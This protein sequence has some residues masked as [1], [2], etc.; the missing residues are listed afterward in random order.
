MNAQ[1]PS[2]N[3]YANQETLTIT[4]ITVVDR[5]N[6]CVSFVWSIRHICG[7]QLES[8]NIATKAM[9]DS[10]LNKTDILIDSLLVGSVPP[11]HVGQVVHCSPPVIGFSE[12]MPFASIS[13]LINCSKTRP[14]LRFSC[15]FSSRRYSTQSVGRLT[16][17]CFIF[18]AP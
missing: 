17:I 9:Y 3:E 10:Q 11:A 8:E 7:T 5:E 14:G 12:G 4:K 6:E 1:E 13:V 15:S 18:S 16:V 2:W